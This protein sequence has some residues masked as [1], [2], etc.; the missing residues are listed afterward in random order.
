MTDND[1]KTTINFM[2]VE[3]LILFYNAIIK[4]CNNIIKLYED[5][6]FLE[7]YELDNAKYILKDL[8]KYTTTTMLHTL[9]ETN[10]ENEEEYENSKYYDMHTSE[11][12]KWLKHLIE[13][14]F[15]FDSERKGS[16]D[17]FKFIETHKLY[18]LYIMNHK[19]T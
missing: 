19:N 2:Q 16:V 8:T 13:C 6:N 14:N 17:F 12:K 5:N 4:D 3:D 15:F 7:S 9:A 10:Y 11:V 18:Q 1:I